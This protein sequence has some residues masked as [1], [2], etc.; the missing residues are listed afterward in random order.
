MFEAANHNQKGLFKGVGVQYAFILPWLILLIFLAITYHLWQVELSSN[1]QRLQDDFDFRVRED[2]DRIE[3][4]LIAYEY[5][6]QGAKGL[7]AASEKVT[8]ENFHNYVNNLNLE[9]NYPGIQGVGFSLIVPTAEKERHIATV[10]KEMAN[11]NIPAYSIKPEGRRD[12]YTSII[13]LE[14]FT[15]RNLRAFGYDMYSEPIRNLAMATAR[16]SG[17]ASSTGK[18]TLLQETS[19]DV[20]AGFLMYLPVYKNGMPHTTLADRRANIIGWVFAPFRINDLLQGILGERANELEHEIYD[21]EAIKNDALMYDSNKNYAANNAQFQS[22]QRLDIPGHHWTLLVRSYPTF[23]LRV[24]AHRANLI[25]LGGLGFSVLFALLTWLLLNGRIQALN[26][27]EKMNR[28][29][30]RKGQELQ[31]ENE[32][33]I[34]LLRN[35]SDGIHIIDLNGNLIESS[36]SF[37]SM[38]G[39]KH[40]EIIGKNVSTWD[41]NLSILEIQKTFTQHHSDIA[42]RIFNARHRR[43]DGTYF[44]VEISVKSIKLK[45]ESLFFCSSRDI[46]ER[47]LADIKLQKSIRELIQANVKVKESERQLSYV[48]DATGEGIWDWDIPAETVSHNKLWCQIADLDGNLIHSLDIFAGLLYPDDREIVF[49]RLQDCLENDQVYRSEHRFQLRSGKII[50][51]Q[52]RGKVVERLPNGDPRRMVGSIVDITERKNQE[53]QLE[54]AKENAEIANLA[55][56]EFLANMSHEIRTPMNAILGMADILSETGL[57]CEQDK[58]VKIFQNAGNHLLELINDILDM[59]KIEAGQ[60][61]LYKEGFSIEQ[62]LS[63][64]VDLH[65]IRAFN[66]EVELVFDIEYGVPDFVF[67]DFKRLKQCLTNLV[68]NAIKFTSSG[69]IIIYVRPAATRHDQ[70]QFS[71]RDNGIGIPIEKQDIIFKAF[72]QADNS[73]TRRFG[74]T[75]L[76]LTITRRLVEMMEGKIWVESQEGLGSTFFFTAT[77]PPI[78][79]PP[80]FDILENLQHVKILITDN[81]EINRIIVWKYLHPLGAEVH[82]AESTKQAID[83]LS[84]A[85]QAG[86]PFNLALFDHQIVENDHVDLGEFIRDNVTFKELKIIILS[87]LDKA[88]QNSRVQDIV[89]TY[90]LKPIKRQELIRAISYELRPKF[91]V[92]A[93]KSIQQNLSITH[94]S[95][96]ILLAEDNPD[97]VV[98]IQ[99]YLKNAPYHIDLAENGLIVLEKFRSNRY[100][101]ILMDVQMPQM[102]GYEATAEIRRIEQIEARS[103]TTIIALTAHALKEDEQR[104][105]DA[106]CNSHL[107]KPIKKKLLLQVLQS[108]IKV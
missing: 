37:A 68:G 98:L 36:V 20:Q 11:M 54:E 107:T 45:G 14:P 30:I 6:L 69:V 53:I 64:I 19:N 80:H 13:Y 84:E 12:L 88:Q 55:K 85:A 67:G 51:V 76:G 18:V 106:G 38:L 89:S 47:T 61:E 41:N 95:L 87:T 8:R 101:L 35:A 29:A 7:F 73:T 63:E 46:S 72:S 40:E 32:K 75:G 17:N 108:I 23:E 86:E 58:Y 59:S 62:L 103:P 99:T 74:G 93:P 90:L 42:H 92:E 81:Y 77:L 57:S 33:N 50:W 105:L 94:T 48:L 100:D 91:S 96:N 28:E 39:Y 24:D 31:I 70:L 9:E 78:A 5:I 44:D 49:K 104:S 16:D 10:R 97:N 3:Q 56:S 60:F 22:I 26:Y 43:K 2:R 71:V 21:G 52:D 27:A 102:G 1:T 79:P 25:A 65:A 82:E 83:L 15:D 66:K 4:R 34:A